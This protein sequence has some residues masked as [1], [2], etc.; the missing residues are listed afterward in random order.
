MFSIFKKAQPKRKAIQ[1]H[2]ID[3]YRAKMKE[4]MIRMGAKEKSFELITDEVIREAIK[5][6]KEPVDVAFALFR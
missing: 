3:S 5:G 4:E 6:D 2:E 1:Q